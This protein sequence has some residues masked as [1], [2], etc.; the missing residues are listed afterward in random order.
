MTTGFSGHGADDLPGD[1][2]GGSSSTTIAPASPTQPA[3]DRGGSGHGSDDLPGDDKGGSSKIGS[4][5]SQ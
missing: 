3:D 1:D 2:K 5:S 4:S